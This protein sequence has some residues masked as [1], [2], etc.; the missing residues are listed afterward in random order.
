MRQ[1]PESKHDNSYLIVGNGNLSKHLCYYFSLKNIPFSIYTR[2]STIPFNE[3][4]HSANRILILIKDDQIEN[5]ILENKSKV[6]DNII[7]IHCSGMLSTNLAESAHPL[8]SFSNKL[9]DL[10]VYEKIPFI[11]EKNR[12]SFTELFPEL[13]NP[14]YAIDS[15]DKILYHAYCVLSGNFTTIIW[16]QFYEFLE[17]RGIPKLAAYEYLKITS[18]NLMTIDNPLTGPLKRNDLEVINKHLESLSNN[19]LQKVYLAMIDVY[20]NMKKENKIEINK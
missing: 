11:T 19:P 14:S 15:V 17:S 8:M 18:N 9:Y 20:K 16:K 10:E 5:F 13:V 7:W 6:S 2:K 4:A 3:L 12:M 1:V